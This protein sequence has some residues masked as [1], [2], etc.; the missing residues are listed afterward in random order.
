MPLDAR[1][2]ALVLDFYADCGITESLSPAAQD[3]LAG[4]DA[5]D[6]PAPDPAPAFSGAHPAP[7]LPA[8]GAA[9]PLGTHDQVADARALLGGVQ[10]LEDLIAAMA[11]VPCPSLQDF[12]TQMVVADGIAG[13]PVM[14]I[15]EAPGA[16]EDQGGRPFI[17]RAGKLLDLMLGAIGLSRQTNCYITNIVPYRPPGNRKPNPSEIQTFM[18][19]LAR[20]IALVRPQVLV[21]LGDTAAKGVLESKTGITRLRGRWASY[22]AQTQEP[23]L[24][25][26]PL[27]VLPTFHPA[28][29]LRTPAQKALS[30]QDLVSLRTKLD[31]LGVDLGGPGG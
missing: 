31:T 30:W 20:H 23:A 26:T 22:G 15:G 21:L 11:Q 14:L 16:E 19:F 6:P 18:P 25:A 8:E 24:A 17:G 9:L 4:V 1:A 27:P 13:A 5:S 3:R 2:L 10:S 29:L 28:Y 12:A 7:L